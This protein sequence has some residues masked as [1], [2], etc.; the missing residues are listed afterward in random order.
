M[1]RVVL[2]L[3]SLSTLTGHTSRPAQRSA[4]GVI[5]DHAR[6]AAN[7]AMP[8]EFRSRNSPPTSAAAIAT[9]MLRADHASQDAVG[10][11]TGSLGY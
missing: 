8:A 11:V 1:L 7:P 9:M 6:P 3:H 4:A 2:E 10:R 5:A